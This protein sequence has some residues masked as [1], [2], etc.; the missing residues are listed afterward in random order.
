MAARISSAESIR[1]VFK[2]DALIASILD[3][4]SIDLSGK[5]P[6]AMG[7]SASIKRIPSIDGL[8]ASW[9][10]QIIGLTDEE[11]GI[12]ADAIKTLFPGAEVKYTLTLLTAKIYTLVT[13]QLKQF[14]EDAKRQAEDAD[15]INRIESAVERAESVKDGRDGIMGLMGPRG[16]QGDPGA[17]GDRGPQGLPGR[18][19]KDLLATDAELDDLKDVSVPDPKVG[20][21]L[22]YDGTSWVSRFAQQVTKG[23]FGSGIPTGGDQYAILEK[24][25]ASSGDVRWTNSPTHE[26]VKFD[27]TYTA[28][29]VNGELLWDPDDLSLNLGANGIQ[30]HIGQETTVLCRNNSNTVTI[31]KGTP[32]MFA[33]TVGNSGR[34]KVRPAVA[35]GSLPGYYFFGVAEQNILGASDGF[36]T[37]FGKIRGVNTAAFQD[38]DILWVDPA[39]PGAFTKTQPQAPNL[40]L[41]V[42]AVIHAHQ[43][44]IIFVRWDTGKGLKDLS[45][46]QVGTPRDGDVLTWV[47]ANNR[48]EPLSLSS[49]VNVTNPGPTGTTVLTS[50]SNLEG[51]T[52]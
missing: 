48:W 26:S 4:I 35:D 31:P 38:G 50:S 43:N 42:A 22:T 19:G 28:T 51:G 46:V 10:I 15:R 23:A 8:E 9:D 21:V 1:S 6:V 13:P 2:K 33:G 44:G 49:N 25:S 47:A 52:F 17:P 40:K 37:T 14:V 18:D 41:P 3:T 45:D 36:V 16:P 29:P 30:L 11:S 39:N 20:Q 32:V 27:T 24:A 5:P 34:L 12:I 7:P